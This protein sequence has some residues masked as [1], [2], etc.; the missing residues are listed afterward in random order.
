MSENATALPFAPGFSC[1]LSY[2]GIFENVKYLLQCAYMVPPAILYAR[3]LY[4]IWV[5]NRKIY[6]QHQFFVIY[7]MDSMVG[8]L[9]LLLDIFI[10]RFF[11]YVPQLCPVASKFFKSHPLFM[12]FYYPLLSYLHCCQPLIQIFLTLN[13]MSSVV[14]P[15]DH[16]KIWRKNLPFIIIF[17]LITPFL[18]IWNTVISPKIV[19]FYFGGFFMMGTKSIEWADIS[20]FLFLVRS[21]AVGITVTSTVIMFLRMSKMKKRLKSS[22]K[23]LCIACVI[24]SICFMIPSFFEALA[25]FNEAYGNSWINFL[26]QPFAWDVLNVGSPFIMIFVSGQLRSHVFDFSILRSQSVVTVQTATVTMNTSN[27]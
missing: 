1:D 26:I 20:L 22:E 2:S 24:H 18:F 4:V 6:I 25:F 12:D 14:W 5:K 23:T 17:I 19:I 3:I 11:V 10:T 21:V 15:V 27:H 7:S 8:L 13:R 16:N 9:L